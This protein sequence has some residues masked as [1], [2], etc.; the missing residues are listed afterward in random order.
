MLCKNSKYTGG[1][2]LV[3]CCLIFGLS[4]AV[5]GQ[6]QGYYSSN[7]SKAI[8][9]FEEAKSFLAYRKLPEAIK[10]LENAVK[11]DP[12]FVEAWWLMGNMHKMDQR[13][14]EVYNAWKIVPSLSRE[15]KERIEAGRFCGSYLLRQGKYEEAEAFLEKVKRE[16][17]P[18]DKL[19][20]V[21]WRDLRHCEYGKTHK[22]DSLN[23]KPLPLSPRVNR[24]P[25]QYFPAVTADEQLL[26]FTARKGRREFDDEDLYI[27]KKENG[28]WQTPTALPEPVNTKGNEGTS[29]ISADGSILVFT[30]CDSHRSKGSCDLFITRRDGEFWSEPEP[31]EQ[32]NSSSWESQ[33][34][35]SADGKW[36]VFCSNRPGGMGGYDL[37]E[38]HQMPNGSWTPPKNL[39]PFINTP[40]GEMSPYIHANGLQLYFASEGH[41]GFGGLDLFITEKD[42]KGWTVPQNLGYPLNSAKDEAGI[43]ITSN[44]RRAY[45][46]RED[47]RDEQIVSSVIFEVDMPEKL[48]AKSVKAVLEGKVV[49]AETNKPIEADVSLILLDSNK[50]M[51]EVNT[52]HSTGKFMMVLPPG[53]PFGL[54]VS[55]E[56][57]LYKSVV[58]PLPEPGSLVAKTLVKLDRMGKGKGIVLN[59]LYFESGKFDLLPQSTAE[60]DRV[61]ALLNKNPKITIEIGGHTDDIGSDDANLLLSQKRAQAVVDYLVKNRLPKIRLTPKGFGETQ[62]VVPNTNDANRQMNRRIELKI[63]GV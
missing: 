11:R 18:T 36:L 27:S 42:G 40:F 57:Y 17:E 53:G 58:L 29:A 49:D 56:G 12:N 51:Y 7:N 32:V 5:F 38:S 35:L 8:K 47:I 41:P 30:I 31:L 45:Y 44:G 19:Y 15:K 33:P 21:I 25:M 16:L 52:E 6:I 54:F 55:A 1:L 28:Q 43:C 50:V 23:M 48:W 10:A 20:P 9:N 39:G 61:I 62:P 24:Y 34:T 4:Q 13:P 37:W 63:T 2:I 59:N 3:F 60:L 26:Y 46:S 14:A 22:A